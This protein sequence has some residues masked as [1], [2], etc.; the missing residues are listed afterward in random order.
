M[1][2][3]EMLQSERLRLIMEEG[4]K[5]I[6]RAKVRDSSELTYIHQA[7]A[8]AAKVPTTVLGSIVEDGC[9]RS[10]VIT[11]KGTNMTYTNILQAA[12]KCAVCS[13]PDPMR[14]PGITVPGV[15]YD[16]SKPPFAQ[17]D[18]SVASNM[19][20]P[21]CKDPGNRVY[22]PPKIIDGKGCQFNRLQYPSG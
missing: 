4:N 16:R 19:Y 12:Q 17:Q 6:A 8:S 2:R 20:T 14:Y 1:R 9:A 3:L 13:D 7:Q 21:A 10:T 15:C 11:G 18:V 5:Y 22:F